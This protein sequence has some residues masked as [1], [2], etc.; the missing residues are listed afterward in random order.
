[1]VRAGTAPDVV[2]IT[3]DLAFS[4]KRKEYELAHA[5]IDTQLL[6]ALPR[7][8]T[9]T[10]ILI[11]PG[12]HDVD[13]DIAKRNLRCRT[14]RE[15]LLTKQTKEGLTYEEFQP[16]VTAFLDTRA[17]RMDLVKPHREYLNFASKYG[18][19]RDA[20]KKRIPWWLSV[21]RINGV[22]VLFSGICSSVLAEGGRKDRG[23][24]VIGERQLD[25]AVHANSGNNCELRV[26]LVHH[27]LQ[28]LSG[29]EADEI[30]EG[31]HAKTNVLLTGHL[32]QVLSR[33]IT[34]PH[35]CCLELRAG[36]VY[37]NSR[38]PNSFQVLEFQPKNRSIVVRYWTWDRASRSW[39]ETRRSP[40]FKLA[41]GP[42]E[43]QKRSR[44]AAPRTRRKR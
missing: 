19:P 42:T 8:F 1:M 22:N 37:E 16:T 27:P 11:V 38:F 36:C 4:G 14:F 10:R 29:I 17:T 34:Y 13:R 6:E 5:W 32:H 23:Q 18:P 43:Y 9:K 24:L 40:P 3:G 39:T 35:N 44:H 33:I 7:N 30:E 2:A 41:P 25:E 21:E 15:F 28:W 31:L 20:V 26:V 12:N